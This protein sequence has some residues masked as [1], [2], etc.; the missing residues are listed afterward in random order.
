MTRISLDKFDHQILDL[1]T[2]DARR[3]GDALAEKVGLSPAACLRRVQR[4]RQSGVIERE[5]AVLSSDYEPRLTRAIV[6]LEIERH[7]PKR[8]DTLTRTFTRL[9]EVER[10]FSITGGSDIAMIVACESMED[11]QDFCERHLYEPP[12]TGYETLVVLREYPSGRGSQP[13]PN[14]KRS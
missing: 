12:V 6:L 9:P 4:L 2:E 3:T 10:M 8:I 13:F 11:Y 7:N 5:I 14:P 1:L